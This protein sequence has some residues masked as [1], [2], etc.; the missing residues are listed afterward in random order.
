MRGVRDAAASASQRDAAF[1]RRA[2]R[3]ARRGWGSTAPNPMVGAVIVRDGEVVGE[4]WHARHGGPHAEVVALGVAGERARGATAYVSLEPC[5]HH[6]KTPPCSEALIAAGVRRVVVAVADPSEVAAGGAARLRAA[7]IDVQVGVEAEAAREVNAPFFFAQRAGRPWVTLKLA[8]SIDGGIADHTR[9]QGWLTGR[10]ARRE[11]HRLRANSD[12]IAVGIGTALADD[13][14]LTV[15][16]VG[17]PRVPPLRLVFDRDARLPLTS[18]LV[19]TLSEG[20]VIVVCASA[21]SPSA[22]GLANAGVRIVAERSLDA[23]LTTLRAE[24][25]VRALLVEGGAGLASA[26]WGAALVDRLIT[27]QAP[28]ILGRGALRAFGSAPA[29][30]AADARRLR[31]IER[32]ALG[33]DAMSVYEVHALES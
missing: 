32:R 31:I 30:R 16:D 20:P 7:G 5:N 15:R 2:L 22:V 19:Q 23:A 25:G 10:R 29:E 3:L 21:S 17:A 18:R 26:L 8:L 33:A 14:A 11:V 28:L 27:F 9:E 13:P 1:M 12:A 24:H 4:G 6:G